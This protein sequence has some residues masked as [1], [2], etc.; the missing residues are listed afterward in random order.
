MSIYIY[1]VNDE[2]V[3]FLKEIEDSKLWQNYISIYKD[4]YPDDDALKLSDTNND[5][6]EVENGNGVGQNK[7][8]GDKKT[9]DK[10][11]ST[12]KNKK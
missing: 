6:K 9:N 8:K 12:K 10:K 5:K 7:N 3:R 1:K 2:I 4:N 11:K